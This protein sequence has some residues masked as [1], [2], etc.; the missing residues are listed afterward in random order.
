V[1]IA[2]ARVDSEAAMG[3]WLAIVLIV[4]AAVMLGF[5]ALAKRSFLKQRTPSTLEDLHAPVKDRVSFEIFSELWTTLGKS[6]GIDPRLVHPTDTFTELSKAD[7]WVLGK[8]EDDLTEWLDKKGLGRLPRPQT[9][10]D[11]ATWVQTSGA[12]ST[13]V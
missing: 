2:H 10:L 3:Q 1:V 9:V 4:G 6:Y 12:S 11:L 13:P 8:G 5:R 7:S